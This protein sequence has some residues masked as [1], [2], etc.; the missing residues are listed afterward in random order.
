MT[1]TRDLARQLLVAFLFAASCAGCVE[2]SGTVQ[3]SSDVIAARQAEADARK[4]APN[5]KPLEVIVTDVYE[6]SALM[7]SYQGETKNGVYE[8]LGVLTL[9]DSAVV[10]AGL[11]HNGALNGPGVERAI[12]GR[13]LHEG[14]RKSV[15]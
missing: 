4:K 10:Q 8:G 1:G 3:L 5:Y 7:A 15:V 14:D 13:V 9:P 2:Q 11:F 6:G 12:D